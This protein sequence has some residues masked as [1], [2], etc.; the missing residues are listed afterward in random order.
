MPLS[1]E[2]LAPVD[3]G[4]SMRFAEPQRDSRNI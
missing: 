3:D 1:A 4:Y 2:I